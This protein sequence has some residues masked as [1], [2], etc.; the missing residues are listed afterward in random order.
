MNASPPAAPLAIPVLVVDD[1]PFM[2]EGL[3]LFLEH[4]GFRVDLAGDAATAWERLQAAPPAAALVDLALPA[5]PSAPAAPAV[6]L[7]LVRQIKAQY[8]AIGVVILSAYEHYLDE[9]LLIIRGGARGLAYTL[10]GRR[11]A[12]LLTALERVLAGH[13]EID[14][15]VRVDQPLQPGEI[16]AQL[17]AEERPWVEQALARF[18]DLTPQE[19]RAAYLLA[20]SYNSQGVARRL[21]IQRADALISRV[22]GKLGLD[23]LPAHAP[24]LRQVAILIK[25]C[26][27]RDLQQRNQG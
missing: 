18:P 24:H 15:E 6:G 3:R 23:E 10:K 9:V 11:S 19:A 16:L 14:P 20:A 8:P 2:R 5:A 1:D 7:E 21:G 22:Y 25:T 27:I 13:V 4:N 17:T 12:G 26:Q